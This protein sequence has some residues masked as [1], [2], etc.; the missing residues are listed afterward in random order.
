[1]A[2]GRTSVLLTLTLT[3][4]LAASGPAAAHPR[5]A[6]AA[7]TVRSDPNGRHTAA[8]IHRFLTAFYGH[9]GPSSWARE[10]RVSDH[11][12]DRAAHTE[13]YDLLLCAQNTPREITIG[14]VTTAQSAGVGR[15]TVTTFW[16]GNARHSFT[17][18]V[19]LDSHPIELQDV[20]CA[21]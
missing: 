5:T 16:D 4:T 1:M 7:D 11:L 20:D 15:A 3:L 8:E 18:Y 9:H 6:P 12:K 14:K 2:G 10:H 13:G 17:A 21:P 19:G